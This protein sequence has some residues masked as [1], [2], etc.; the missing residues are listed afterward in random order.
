M[1]ATINRVELLKALGKVKGAIPSRGTLPIIT[2]VA[3]LA[4][5][6]KIELQGTD[7]EVF[8][9]LSC[10]ADVTKDG[11]VCVLIKT[12]EPFL[13][14]VKTETVVITM[15]DEKHMTIKAGASITVDG[16]DI[17]DFPNIQKVKEKFCSVVNLDNIL[18]EVGYAVA[19]EEKRLS[20]TG[21]SFICDEKEGKLE[22]CSADGFRLVIGSIKTEMFAQEPKS[23]ILP[24]A[25]AN[26]IEKHMPGNVEIFRAEESMSFMNDNIVMTT[27]LIQ[28]N[29]PDYRQIIPKNTTY[30]T[31]DSSEMKRALNIVSATTSSNIVR[32]KATKDS[33]VVSTFDKEVG[34]TSTTVPSTGMCKI[35]FNIKYLRDVLNRIEG[36]VFA[37]A[38]I[39]GTKPVLIK[40]NDIVHVIMPMFVQWGKD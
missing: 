23:F 2:R 33:L 15:P 1:N 12:L 7:L 18:K 27:K 32:F 14:N 26:I 37:S 20:L 40:N 22:L 28:G 8:V 30:F 38:D 4:T 21:I 17:A 36:T 13:K 24:K 39:N 34:E 16:M 11:G 5:Q 3:I 9:T 19:T 29:Y 10:K 25:A 6:G 35:A 31:F